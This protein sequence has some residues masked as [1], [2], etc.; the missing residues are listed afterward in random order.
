MLEQYK[1]SARAALASAARA[2]S[3]LW[4]AL[5]SILSCMCDCA[6]AESATSALVKS[7]VIKPVGQALCAH[8]ASGGAAGSA[9]A[10]LARLAQTSRLA[11][12]DADSGTAADSDSSVGL[13]S[14]AN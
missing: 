14:S 1:H 3:P 7:V 5:S 10:L 13:D 9:A 2:D 11:V 4:P 12:H 8:V 6:A